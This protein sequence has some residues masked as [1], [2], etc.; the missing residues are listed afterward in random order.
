MKKRLPVYITRTYSTHN[1]DFCWIFF[2]RLYLKPHLELFINKS[3]DFFFDAGLGRNKQS[4]T[5]W[6]TEYQPKKL[7]SSYLL[8]LN[9]LLLLKFLGAPEIKT[10]GGRNF[11]TNIFR[12]GTASSI[13]VRSLAT[14]ECLRPMKHD[15]YFP[16]FR[17]VNLWH[18]SMSCIHNHE[19][20]FYMYC[21]T[22]ELKT[23]I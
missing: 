5:H 9:L 17:V 22:Y 12:F 23:L 3:E 18:T 21:G 20:L 4:H 6:K 14:W 19:G 7:Y 10:S 16:I 11:K 8:I 13:V 2:N 15:R 1:Y